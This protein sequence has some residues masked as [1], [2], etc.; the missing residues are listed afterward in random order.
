MRLLARVLSPLP[1]ALALA[2]MWAVPGCAQHA[3][4]SGHKAMP[5]GAFTGGSA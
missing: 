5:K 1:A 4:T 3:M 2:C